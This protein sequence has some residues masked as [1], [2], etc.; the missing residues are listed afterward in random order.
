MAFSSSRY[1]ADAVELGPS[2]H[3][4]IVSPYV[5]EPYVAVGATKPI[6]ISMNASAE[7]EGL[8]VKLVLPS[9]YTVIR[10]WWRCCHTT[11]CAAIL[12]HDL[13]PVAGHFQGVE[14]EC[15][16]IIEEVSFDLTAK[17]I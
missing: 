14:V 11:I 1:I 16:E 13:P 9:D 12:D 17:Y 2:V 15:H 3:A 7:D 6:P 5:V 4:G 10:P 8:Q